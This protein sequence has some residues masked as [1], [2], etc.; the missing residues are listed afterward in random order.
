MDVDGV[1]GVDGDFDGVL[2]GLLTV[3]EDFDAQGLIVLE[4]LPPYLDVVG[5]DGVDGVFEGYFYSFIIHTLRMFDTITCQH[6]VTS[7]FFIDLYIP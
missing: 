2:G 1:Y 4:Y 3:I 6:L 7:F 5:L